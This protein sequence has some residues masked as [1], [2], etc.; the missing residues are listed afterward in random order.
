MISRRQLL[1]EAIDEALRDWDF[2]TAERM[3]NEL[4]NLDDSE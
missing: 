4:N 3:Q 1:I 2:E